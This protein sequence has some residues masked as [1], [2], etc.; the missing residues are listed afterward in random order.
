V[1]VENRG[2]FVNLHRAANGDIVS[3]GV[4]HGA[5]TPMYFNTDFSFKHEFKVSK[6]NE[7]MRLGLELDILNLL[8]QHSALAIT[9]TPL[10]GGAT[11]TIAG[12][13]ASGV[14]WKSLLTG[15]DYTGVSNAAGKTFN[16]AYGLPNLF[17][18]SR[19][20]RLMVMF[21]F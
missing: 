20:M 13:N 1:Y 4:V 7:G 10:A 2:N 3:D 19:N 12:A 5:R 15:W 18:A 9:P 16:N 14:D 6:N 8:N 17:Q 21:K 11:V